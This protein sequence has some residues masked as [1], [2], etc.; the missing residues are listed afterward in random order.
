MKSVQ[1]ELPDKLAAEVEAYVRA[2]WFG[3]EADVIRTALAEFIRRNRLEL[4]E[5]FM[6]ED[7]D[8]ALK[9]KTPAS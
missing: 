5:R 6:R 1:V 4:L 3:S 8:W 9:L 7:I 2:G